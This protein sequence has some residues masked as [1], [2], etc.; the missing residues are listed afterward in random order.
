VASASVLVRKVPWDR[1]VG[2][3]KTFAFP[4]IQVSP[5]GQEQMNPAAGTNL[6]DDVGYG[7]LV[8]VMDL[9][10]QSQSNLRERRLRWREAMIR[11]FRHARLP[12]ITE[13]FDCVIE[14]NVIVH[15]P[16]WLD[17]NLW[18]SFFVLR[19]IA[20]ETRGFGT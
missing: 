14:P 8:S 12:G 2:T 1:D 10:N 16:N 11:T 19:F 20:R 4:I 6:K 13:V 9:D 17:H 15:A 5:H 3:G 7:V 18:T